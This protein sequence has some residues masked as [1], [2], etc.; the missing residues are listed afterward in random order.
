MVVKIK[1]CEYLIDEWCCITVV[2]PISLFPFFRCLRIL[3]CALF[4]VEYRCLVL[5]LR[6]GW[7]TIFTVSRFLGFF[8]IFVCSFCVLTFIRVYFPY[9]EFCYMGGAMWVVMSLC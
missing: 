7:I 2:S 4:L 8:S 9:L 6:I 1:I 5:V 3:G